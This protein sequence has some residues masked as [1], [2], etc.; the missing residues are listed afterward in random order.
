[1]DLV[2]GHPYLVRKALYLIA[3]GAMSARD[4]FA[5]AV[6]ERGPFGDHLRYHLFR[7]YDK[8]ELVQVFLQVVQTHTCADERI[9]F[10]L[11]GAGLVRRRSGGLEVVPRCQLYEQYFEQHLSL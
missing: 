10:K 7:I 11:R 4:L 3:S 1:M 2:N 5:Q 6:K 8:P 9:F